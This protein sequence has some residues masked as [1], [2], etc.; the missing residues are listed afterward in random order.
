[1][2]RAGV[3]LDRHPA[4]KDVTDLDLALDEAVRLG[5]SEATVTGVL[6]E[7]IDHSL[8]AIGSLAGCVA[9]R[10]TIAEPGLSGWIVGVGESVLLEGRGSTVS[11]FAVLTEA[12]VSVA[13]VRWEL[14]RARLAPLSSRGLSNVIVAPQALVSVDSGTVA[15][16]SAE[17]GGTKPAACV[18]RNNL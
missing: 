14:D 7:R 13:G 17:V 3:R 4:D 12:V 15:V 2:E 5:C 9:L 6:G 16:L 1:L 18:R 11:V 8:A 10:L